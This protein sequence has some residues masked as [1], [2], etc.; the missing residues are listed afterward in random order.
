MQLNCEERL[1]S[2]IDNKKRDNISLVSDCGFCFGESVNVQGVASD[3]LVIL[4][5]EANS[6]A[7]NWFG[8]R[9]THYLRVWHQS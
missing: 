9:E 7:G 8:F 2:K 4:R 6:T 5:P 3:F 1:L